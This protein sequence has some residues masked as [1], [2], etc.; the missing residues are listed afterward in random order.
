MTIRSFIPLLLLLAFVP[1][2]TASEPSTPKT[3]GW[4]PDPALL[5]KLDDQQ[6]GWLYRDER[7][8]PYTLP[9]P[10]VCKDGTRVTSAAQWEAKRRPETLDLFRE[11]VYGRPPAD[12][13]KVTFDVLARDPKALDGAATLKRAR[14]TAADAAGKSFSFELAV[15]TPNRSAH[16]VPAFL[17]INNR[18]LA[19]ADPSR[20]KKDDFWPAEA[21]IARGYATAVFRTS[22]VDPD[23]DGPEARKAGV[24]GAWPAGGGTPGQDAWGTVGAW[25]WGASRALDYLQTDPAIDGKKV[26]VIGHS[27]GGKTALWAAAQDTRFALAIANCSGR[28]GAS[29]SRRRFGETVARINQSFPYWFCGNFKRFNNHEDQLPVDQHQLLALIAPRALCVADADADF[30]ADQRGEFL[31]LAAAGP[32][33]ALYGFEGFRPDEM[34]PLETPL[35]RGPMGYHIRRGVHNLTRYNWERYLDF[36]DHLW[37]GHGAASH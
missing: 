6:V 37:P 34:P 10:L 18:G 25:A 9:D 29:L 22:D 24:R 33:Y 16:P 32:V 26:A 4:Q 13:A 21:I 15:L 7:V 8:R 3:P 14:I 17:L 19:S 23:K 30:W 35:V 20:A 12:P 1:L 5:K 27:R 31:S 2:S 36:A 11:F 28:G